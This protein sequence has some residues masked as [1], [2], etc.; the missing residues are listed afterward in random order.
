MASSL[1]TTC[2]LVVLTATAAHAHIQLDSPPQQTPS[3]KQGPCGD[4]GGLR[5]EDVSEFAPGENITVVWRETINHPSHYRISFDPDGDDDFR[6][7]T[8]FMDFTGNPTVLVDAIADPGGELRQEVQLPDVECESCTLQVIQVMYDK[9]PFGDGNDIYYQ[10]ADLVLRRPAVSPDPDLAK[11]DMLVAPNDSGPQIDAEPLASDANEPDGGPSAADAALDP[12]S[13]TGPGAGAG[14][15]E[16]GGG[17]EG[18][19][20]A[21][22]GGPGNP[23]WTGLA[24][25]PLVRRGRRRRCL[26]S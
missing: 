10:C 20:A 12:L 2:L 14:R 3:Q 21:A 1:P 7:P 16:S 19:C 25:W 11:V 18:C 13:D 15:I 4:G 9:P 26:N 22:G 5:G 17:D 8:G 6:D 23:I 24:L